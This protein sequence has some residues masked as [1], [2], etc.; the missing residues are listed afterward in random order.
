MAFSNIRAQ[1]IIVRS[2]SCKT[3]KYS[4]GS[5]L[6]TRRDVMGLLFGVSIISLNSPDADGADLPPEEKPKLCDDA[7]E[8]ELEK[9]LASQ[10]QKETDKCNSV[11]KTQLIS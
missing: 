1:A 11:S 9:K 4:N 3:R 5:D 2:S 10:Y 6:V 8:K 7:C